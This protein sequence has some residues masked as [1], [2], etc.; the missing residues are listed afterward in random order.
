MVIQEPPVY[1]DTIIERANETFNSNMH[2]NYTKSGKLVDFIVWPTLYLCKDGSI[3]AKGVAQCKEGI[4]HENQLDQKEPKDEV[5]KV[6]FKDL[7]TDDRT[8]K[9][10]PAQI[11]AT[12]MTE[13]KEKHVNEE[14]ASK[15]L[16]LSNIKLHENES[17]GDTNENISIETFDTKL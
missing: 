11:S 3:L 17:S 14:N 4:G 16:T 10:P 6:G 15:A 12:A 9:I 1:I 5:Q 2:K 8:K 7:Q 13:V